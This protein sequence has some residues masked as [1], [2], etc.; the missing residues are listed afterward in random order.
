MTFLRK[1]SFAEKSVAVDVEEEGNT[2]L[3]FLNL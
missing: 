1:G 3:S 2:D